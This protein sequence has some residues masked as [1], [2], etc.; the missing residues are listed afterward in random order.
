MRNKLFIT[1]LLFFATLLI[2]CS[3]SGDASPSGNIEGVYM[4]LQSGFNSDGTI[5]KRG[6]YL[7]VYNDGKLKATQL[8]PENG[9]IS[10]NK[11]AD[12]KANP[13]YWAD[14]N[15]Q[16]G[17]A[18][19][20]TSNNRTVSIA[21]KN[22]SIFYNGDEFVKVPSVDALTLAGVYSADQDPLAVQAFGYEPIITFYKDGRFEDKTALYYVNSYDDMFKNPGNGKYKINNLTI[23]MTYND[24]RGSAS[25]PFIN[26]SGAS[27]SSI[28]IGEKV[29]LKK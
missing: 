20:K 23:E 5:L 4:G 15:L 19:F 25:F 27:L 8:L 6:Y 7:L 26:L 21:F 10:F 3:G 2:A 18:V 29:I 14:Y 9:F 28:Q 22:N 13:D 1:V 12:I 17:K 24:G 11:E 16:T